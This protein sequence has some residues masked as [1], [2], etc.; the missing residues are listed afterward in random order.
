MKPYYSHGGI[1]IYHGDCMD[2]LPAISGVDCVIADP[3]FNAGKEYGEHTV[4][5]RPIDEYRIW[6]NERLHGVARS[7][8]AGA[9]YWIMNDSK[10]I[11]STQMALEDAGLTL[12]NMV[13][14][15]YANPTPSSVR[16]PKTWRPIL[17]MRKPGMPNKWIPDADRIRKETVYSNF[18][19]MDDNRQ[20]ADLWPDI[21]KLVGGF[22]AQSELLL[23]KNKKFAH[24]AQMP[25]GLAERPIMYSTDLWDL[26]LDPFMGSGTTLRVAKNLG[27]RAIGI[28]IEEKFCEMA[29]N[30]L[31]QEA[32]IFDDA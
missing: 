25:Q 16:F 22:L 5:D 1:T 9:T 29:A 20:L 24:L 26:V 13:V 27:R 14:W 23:D 7:G 3:P 12:E 11:A 2:V 4:D 19:R 17:F 31:S 30:R 15:A 28:E 10:H 18:A 32:M 21:P 6:L 8:R